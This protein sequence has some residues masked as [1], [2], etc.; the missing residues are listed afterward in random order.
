[1]KRLLLSLLILCA[2]SA[3]AQEAT[4]NSPVA[5]PAE[6]KLTV[7][8]LDLTANQAVISLSV[9]DAASSEIRYY[10]VVVPDA[11]PATS[12]ATV[13]GLVTA[14]DTAAPSETGGVLRRLHFRILTYMQGQGYIPN[15]TLVP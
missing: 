15:V 9:M 6:S 3:S 5:R 1:M 10:N 12:T 2:V 4:L 7:K 14:I 8:R 13:A 11:S